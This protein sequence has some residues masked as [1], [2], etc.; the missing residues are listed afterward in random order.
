MKPSK[1]TSWGT[2]AQWYSEHLKDDDTYHAKVVLPNI[3]RLVD[4]KKGQHV[5]EIGCGEGY[6]AEMLAE[7]GSAVIGCDISPELIALAKK[8]GKATYHVTPAQDLSM[9]GTD[10]FDIVLAV[11]TLQNMERLDTVMKEV[12]RVLKPTGRFVFVINHPVL[13]IPQSSSWDYDEQKK[14][15]YRRIDAYLSERRIAI[16]MHPGKERKSMTYSFH[17]SLQE[18][19][20]LLRAAGFALTRLEEWISHKESEPGPRAKAENT[21]RKE[22]PLFMMIEATCITSR[23]EQK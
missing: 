9:F 13:L 20:K 22:F 21:A 18:Y 12:A 15:Q 6:F 23:G 7:K 5:L 17:R 2:E 8:K 11:L 1:K 10:S 4:P 3:L 16:D 14:V 19:M